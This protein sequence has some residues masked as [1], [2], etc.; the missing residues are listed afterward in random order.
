[1]SDKLRDQFDI[2]DPSRPDFWSERFDKGYTP[3]D[4]Q[5]V[6][7]VFVEFATAIEGGDAPAGSPVS[8]PSVLIPG[9]GRAHEARWLAD[10]GF[11]V[12]AVDFS[13]AAV[14]AA[15]D[16][17]GPHAHIVREAD[18]FDFAPARPVG[19]VYERTFFCAL[20]PARRADYAAR[21]AELLPP[22]GL[23]A[24][25]FFVT[26]KPVGPPFGTS[27]DELHRLLDAD[28]ELVGER[29]VEDSMPIFKGVERWLEWRRR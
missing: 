5:G 16:Q 6:P 12:E 27:L 9:C 1:M 26:E 22:G 8:R 21:M 15:R 10:H 18:F 14:A 28:F 25:L 3:W 20:P 24:G 23:L 2:H 4:H 29:P 13:R 17:L 7:G 19:W 11:A